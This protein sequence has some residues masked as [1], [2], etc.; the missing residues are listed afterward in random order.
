MATAQGGELLV[1][2]VRREQ[3][4]E[5]ENF[6]ALLRDPDMLPSVLALDDASLSFMSRQVWCGRTSGESGDRQG[7]TQ[8]KMTAAPHPK[9]R[10]LF[11]RS[12]DP[13]NRLPTAPRVKKTAK[14]TRRNAP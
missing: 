3:I 9:R 6:L 8:A 12:T 13:A 2:F 1:A 10:Q 11:L 7:L 5:A 4:E 14:W